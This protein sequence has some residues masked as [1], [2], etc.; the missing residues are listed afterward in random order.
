[1]WLAAGACV[2]LHEVS[3]ERCAVQ[4]IPGWRWCGTGGDGKTMDY[5]GKVKGHL[6]ANEL[7]ML[8]FRLVMKLDGWNE[9][10]CW[11]LL[12][13][14]S[15][16]INKCWQRCGWISVDIPSVS[17]IHTHSLTHTRSHV[18]KHQE[19][20]WVIYRILRYFSVHFMKCRLCQIFFI[21]KRKKL[22][23]AQ[24]YFWNFDGIIF[25]YKAF[26]SASNPT[27]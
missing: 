10:K 2:Y 8:W 3:R 26:S 6:G 14:M 15:V 25:L 20:L 17:G 11:L 13:R 22:Q 18:Y 27:F 5:V 12:Y 21:S 16:H 9:I 19:H 23:V 24:S 4:P 1:M 7:H